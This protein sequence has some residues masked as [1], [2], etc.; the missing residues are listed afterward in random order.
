MNKILEFCQQIS[1]RNSWINDSTGRQYSQFFPYDCY[2]IQNKSLVNLG[3][4]SSFVFL[5]S[6][7]GLTAEYIGAFGI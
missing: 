1:Q 4:E 5:R 2:M 6:D 3:I 7:V